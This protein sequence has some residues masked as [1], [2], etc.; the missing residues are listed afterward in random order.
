[1][2]RRAVTAPGPIPRS[3]L[4]A[5]VA[6]VVSAAC[7]GSTTDTGVAGS[8]PDA[9]STTVEDYPDAITRHLRRLAAEP[10]PVERSALPPRHLDTEVFPESLVERSLIVSGGPPPDG[11]PSIDE[12]VFQ[13]ADTV[14]WLEPEEAVLAL[15][16][17]GSMRAYPVQVLMWHEI[18]NDVVDGRPVTVTYCPLCNSG[19]AFDPRV[20]GEIL[21][22]GT[23][24]SLYHSALVMYDR[25]TETL[26]THFDGRAVVGTLVGTQL[27]LLS[28]A[29]VSWRDFRETHPEAPVLTRETGHDR[30][31]GRNPYGAY[32]QMDGPLPGFFAGDV[33]AR[34]AAMARVVGLGSGDGA[35]AVALEHLARVGTTHTMLDG[36]PVVVWH[37]PGTASSL[38]APTVAGGDDI[39]ATGAFVAVGPDGPL[40]FERDG[41]RFTDRETGSEW[42]LFGEAVAGPLTGFRLTPVPHLDTFWFAWSTYQPDTGL[43]R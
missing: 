31:Y 35:V 33:D 1:M 29:T 7:S 32:D 40:A 27:E 14:D 3:L 38:Q 19:V 4:V 9:T 8:P 43:I 24:G 22:F 18:V 28:L 15:D 39:G 23:S 13:R 16:L 10:R 11:I 36:R 17:D 6:M 21:D 5:L 34:N 30:P 12:P 2:T 20:G 41:R 42:N 26:W 37:V 25:Q